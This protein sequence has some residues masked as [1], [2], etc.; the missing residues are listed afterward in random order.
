MRLCLLIAALFML[1][2]TG[3][4]G[5]DAVRVGIGGTCTTSNNCELGLTCLGNLCPVKAINL[6]FCVPA[7]ACT[8][9]SCATG[10]ECVSLEGSTETLCVPTDICPAQGIGGDACEADRECATGACKLLACDE[11]T[12]TSVCI[13]GGCINGT[14]AEGEIMWGDPEDDA[15]CWCTPSDAC[16]ETSPGS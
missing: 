10:Q 13:S 12:Q 2:T 7:G 14:C 11:K 3:C 1:T 6:N 5:E 15:S 16:P 4:A 9:N 8:A